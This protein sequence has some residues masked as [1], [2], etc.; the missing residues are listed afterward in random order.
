MAECV[1]NFEAL[2]AMIRGIKKLMGWD[3]S[4]N[5]NQH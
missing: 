5:F 2:E 1:S 3:G 4:G